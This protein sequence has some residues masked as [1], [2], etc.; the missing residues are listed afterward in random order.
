MSITAL[1]KKLE[2]AQKNNCLPKIV[3]PIHFSGL[4]CDMRS[5]HALSEKY[6][7]HIIEDACHAIRGRYMNEPVGNCKIVMLQ[8]SA[9]IRLRISLPARVAWLLLMMGIWR[10]K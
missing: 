8:C 9:S 3:M 5:I 2:H 1:A 7:F 4:P 6:G 10:Q